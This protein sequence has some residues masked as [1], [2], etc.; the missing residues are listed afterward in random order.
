[1]MFNFNGCAIRNRSFTGEEETISETVNQARQANRSVSQSMITAKSK[2]TRNS[3]SHPYFTLYA[4][5][6]RSYGFLLVRPA[7]ITQ[8]ES[9]TAARALSCSGD[10]LYLVY[11]FGKGC[12]VTSV[13]LGALQRRRTNAAAGRHRGSRRISAILFFDFDLVEPPIELGG[14]PFLIPR[15]FLPTCF[16][17][18]FRLAINNLCR[19]QS[20]VLILRHALHIQ[21]QLFFLRVAVQH[22]QH[23]KCLGVMLRAK[24]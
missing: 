12:V 16:L 3:K 22:L 9:N 4:H 15:I 1:M 20:F 10:S 14:Q 23:L 5:Y 24:M 13:H 11:P 19:L 21:E 7:D 17:P 8:L 18:F 2:V 6:K